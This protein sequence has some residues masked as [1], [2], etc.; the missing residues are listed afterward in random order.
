MEKMI[1]FDFNMEKSS[2]FFQIPRL[3]Y[4]IEKLNPVGLPSGFRV[5]DLPS[6]HPIAYVRYI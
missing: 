1:F 2:F 5:S 3:H 4:F 6:G